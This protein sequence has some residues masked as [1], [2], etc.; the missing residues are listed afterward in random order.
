VYVCHIGVKGAMTT[1]AVPLFGIERAGCNMCYAMLVVCVYSRQRDTRRLSPAL[2]HV[3]G[4][5]APFCY[6]EQSARSIYRAARNSD[7]KGSGTGEVLC[8]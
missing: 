3:H 5:Y 1:G 2:T 4:E 7:S 8:V 6:W